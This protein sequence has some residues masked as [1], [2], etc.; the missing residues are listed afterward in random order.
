MESGT[1]FFKGVSSHTIVVKV[2]NKPKN[3]ITIPSS[4]HIT[5]NEKNNIYTNLL[6]YSR[7]L[8]CDIVKNAISVIDKNNKRLVK[9]DDETINVNQKFKEFEEKMDRN[10]EMNKKIEQKLNKLLLDFSTLSILTN[11]PNPTQ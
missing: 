10:L 2:N 8:D 4:D 9:K 1:A 7:V 5:I 3:L 6:K 11:N